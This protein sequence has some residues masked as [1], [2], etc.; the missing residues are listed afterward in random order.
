MSQGFSDARPGMEGYQTAFD[1][2]GKYGSN[3]SRPYINPDV[4][5]YVPADGQNCIRIVDPIELIQLRVYFMDVFHHREVGYKNDYFLCDKEM[6]RGPC[7]MCELVTPDLWDTDKEL[8]KKRS[9]DM[10][11]LMWVLDLQKPQEAH[12]L[13][14]W[15][16]PRTLS[17]E[18]LTQSRRPD[19]NVYMDIA[20]PKEGV[21]VFFNRAGKGLYTKYTGVQLGQ[22][23]YPIGDDVAFQRFEFNDIL[24]WHEYAEMAEAMNMTGGATPVAD[25]PAT[26]A[27]DAASNANPGIPQGGAA[28]AAAANTPQTPQTPSG[29]VTTGAKALP[30]TVGNPGEIDYS[31]KA[32]I[33]P[34]N[35]DCFRQEY[36]K[37]NECETCIDRK[38]CALPWP[39]F[40]APTKQAKPGKIS[41]AAKPVPGPSRVTVPENVIQNPSGSGNP[42]GNLAGGGSKITDAQ[43]RLQ[44][45]IAKRKGQAQ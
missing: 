32:K 2:K 9:P 19:L 33:D 23:A 26:P 39:V 20:H 17:D 7:P 44:A 41:K 38:L 34:N 31:D 40:P 13:K 12:I 29:A 5:M 4:P 45:E 24:M 10:R 15:S 37:Y 18:I 25:G 14:L 27:Y 8:A 3:N 1:N 28:A 36:D 11:R 21:P 16:A 6:G 43:A 42:V 30:D 22:Q 35:G